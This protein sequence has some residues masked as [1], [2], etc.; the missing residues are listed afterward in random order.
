MATSQ[1]PTDLSSNTDVEKVD[2]KELKDVVSE[3]EFVHAGL[4][5]S[6]KMKKLLWKTDLHVV[7]PLFV[8]FLLAFLDRTN[9]GNANVQGLSKGLGLSGPQYNISLFIFFIPYILLEVP[10]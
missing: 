1:I 6:A 7:P 2:M 3:T 5:D 10:S 9:I 4:A 8:L